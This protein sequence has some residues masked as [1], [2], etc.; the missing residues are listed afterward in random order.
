[1]LEVKCAGDKLEM[2]VA[3]LLHWKSHQHFGQLDERRVGNSEVGKFSFKLE[4]T[5]RSWNDSNSVFSYQN[6]SNFGSNFPISFRTFK[7][8]VFYNY[9]FRLHVSPISVV[10]NISWPDSKYFDVNWLNAGMFWLQ[11]YAAK[12]SCKIVSK[13]F[14]NFAPS[15]KPFSWSLRIDWYQKFSKIRS[16]SW[17]KSIAKLISSEK[18]NFDRLKV[19]NRNFCQIRMI[20]FD[21][22]YHLLGWFS[23]SKYD[24]RE[25]S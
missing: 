4:R 14:L 16:K 20:V 1:M 7:I 3:D 12:R 9:P 21:L 8:L 22:G 25:N 18:C 10:N 19:W 5:N 2:L 24:S 23:C 15:K 11:A 13:I 6:F 17:S